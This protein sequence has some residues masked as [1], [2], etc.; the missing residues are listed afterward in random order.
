LFWVVTIG[1]VATAAFAA[2]ASLKVVFCSEDAI[3]VLG[4][5]IAF[6]YG[7][8]LFHTAKIQL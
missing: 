4:V 6:F 7:D 1:A 3:A 8:V 2:I 5:V